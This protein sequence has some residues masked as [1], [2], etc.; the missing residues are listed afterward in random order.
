MRSNINDI[1]LV[2]D[3]SPESLGMLNTA[4]NTQ[5]YT[6][7]VALNGIQA[8]SIINTKNIFSSMV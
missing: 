5:G 7:L 6:A 3:D 4:L 8:L 2:V 1:V